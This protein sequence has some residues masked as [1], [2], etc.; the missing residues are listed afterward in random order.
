MKVINN[1]AFS[2]S[3]GHPFIWLA[4]AVASRFTA[5]AAVRHVVNSAALAGASYDTAKALG[6]NPPSSGGAA[7]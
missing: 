3:G 6:G 7:R 4:L 1:Q 5:N 2:V